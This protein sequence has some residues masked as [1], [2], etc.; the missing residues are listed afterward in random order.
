MK[1]CLKGMLKKMKTWISKIKSSKA[2]IDSN[3]GI[4]FIVF[5]FGSDFKLC[6]GTK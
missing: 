4:D 2:S 3:I 6:I 1:F 5:A